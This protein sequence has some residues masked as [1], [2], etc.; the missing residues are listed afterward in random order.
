MKTKKFMAFGVYD[1]HCP[2]DW[3]FDFR[4]NSDELAKRR[5][6][7]FIR[8]KRPLRA[9]LMCGMKLIDCYISM[10]ERQLHAVLKKPILIPFG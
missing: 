4:V 7:W 1:G 10:R 2:G 9:K 6:R 3:G 5:F 8:C